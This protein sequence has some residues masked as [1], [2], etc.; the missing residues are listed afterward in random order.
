MHPDVYIRAITRAAHDAGI[1]KW[2]SSHALRHTFATL[3]LKNGCDIRTVQ[4][5]LG[6]EDVST[7]EG[8]IHSATGVGKLG[9]KSPLDCI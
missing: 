9:V 5:L 4:E 7:T 8:Y 1:E 6:H 2:V 3:L